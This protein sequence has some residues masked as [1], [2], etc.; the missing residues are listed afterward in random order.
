MTTLNLPRPLGDNVVAYMENE[1]F[2]LTGNP[3][4]EISYTGQKHTGVVQIRFP[5]RDSFDDF[6]TIMMD[7]LRSSW[8]ETPEIKY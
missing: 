7:F 1:T 3:A 6:W 2:L 5:D 4:P 8:V